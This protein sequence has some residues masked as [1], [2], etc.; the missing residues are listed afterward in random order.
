MTDPTR[1]AAIEALNNAAY[2]D[3]DLQFSDEV[4]D[5]LA[6]AVLAVAR[7]AYRAEGWDEGLRAGADMGMS[8]GEAA[9]GIKQRYPLVPENP[10]RAAA[11]EEK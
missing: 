10:Y 5:S 9:V 11:E 2:Y 6:D 4:L 7:P 8:I 3:H 1:D